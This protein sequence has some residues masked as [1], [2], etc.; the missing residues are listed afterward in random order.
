MPTCVAD[1]VESARQLPDGRFA[2]ALRDASPLVAHKLVLACGVVD[3]KPDVPG[4]EEHYGAS[5][6]HCPAC[7]GYEAKDRDVVALGWSENLRGSRRRCW[8]GPVRSRW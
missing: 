5:V 2:V 1:V 6:F 3:A 4:L 7:D 8:A